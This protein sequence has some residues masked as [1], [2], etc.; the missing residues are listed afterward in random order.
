MRDAPSRPNC[1]QTAFR[2]FQVWFQK[3]T[4][5]TP[6][7]PSRPSKL[8]IHKANFST[9][10]AASISGG[11]NEQRARLTVN[12]FRS[13][14]KRKS[15]RESLSDEHFMSAARVRARARGAWH[16]HSPNSSSIGEIVPPHRRAAVFPRL[17]RLY[18]KSRR[19]RVSRFRCYCRKVSRA[20]T[21]TSH[22]PRTLSGRF[23]CAAVVDYCSHRRAW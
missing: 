16:V 21:P 8:P 10:R 6:D 9:K 4:H 2:K 7:Q 15:D 5:N 23:C 20:D 19:Q 11:R 17:W 1:L 12:N 18:S 3:R 14:V 13:S 22:Q